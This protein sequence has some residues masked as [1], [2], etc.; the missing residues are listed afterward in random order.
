MNQTNNA[1]GIPLRFTSNA[2][3]FK[4]AILAVSGADSYVSPDWYE[5]PDQVPT[6]NYVAVHLRGIL[7]QRPQEEMREVLDHLTEFFEARLAPKKPWRT[8]KMPSV[9]IDRMMRII[10]PFRLRVQ[11]VDGT[12]KLAQNKRDTARI[13]AAS[14]VRRH[15]FGLEARAIAALMMVPPKS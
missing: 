7:E 8:E 6:W 12:W 5:I 11:S 15:G 3:R 13:S 14:H 4:P 9:L 10:V 2:N 1:L